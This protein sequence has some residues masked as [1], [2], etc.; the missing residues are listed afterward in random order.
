M[1]FYGVLSTNQQNMDL[2][3]FAE[4]NFTLQLMKLLAIYLIHDF[5]ENCADLLFTMNNRRN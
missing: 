4:E 2:F 1:I 5:L 3:R